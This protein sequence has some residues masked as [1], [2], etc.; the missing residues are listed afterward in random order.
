MASCGSC[1]VLLSSES[2]WLKSTPLRFALRIP[3]EKTRCV[4][5]SLCFGYFAKKPS[6]FL[7]MT[8]EPRSFGLYSK[9]VCNF[10]IQ[11]LITI[12]ISIQRRKKFKNSSFFAKP[13]KHFSFTPSRRTRTP[14]PY[15]SSRPPSTLSL[16]PLLLPAAASPPRLHPCLP[17]SPLPVASSLSLSVPSSSRRPSP[18]LTP[19]RGTG[20]RGSSASL[21]VGLLPLPLCAARASMDLA[22]LAWLRS[23]RQ[24]ENA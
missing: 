18:P 12:F 6:Y 11:V 16:P 20:Q 19:P 9:H 8:I 7:R 14:T 21:P 2:E 4:S 5:L 17:S 23:P 1:D 13:P 10:C 24:R 22:G 15:P 3:R